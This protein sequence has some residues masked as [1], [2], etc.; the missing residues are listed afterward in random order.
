MSGDIFEVIRDRMETFSASQKIIAGMILKDYAQVVNM[1]SRDLAKALSVSPSTVVRFAA[2]LGYESYPGMLRSLRK[3]LLTALDPPMKKIHDTVS[4]LQAGPMDKLLE[5]VVAHETSLLSSIH[6]D[7]INAV[8][9]RVADFFADARDIFIT[10]ARSSFPI[11]DYAGYMMRNLYKNVSAFPSSS[12]DRYERLEDLNGSDMVIC[13]SLHRYYKSTVDV[14]RFAKSKGAFVVG[15]TDYATSPIIRHCGEVLLLPGDRSRLA[16][17]IEIVCLL[18]AMVFAF[19]Q[20]KGDSAKEFLKKRAE[21]MMQE[22]MY[23][24]M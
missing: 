2:A 14:A 20:I 11:A 10:G 6:N 18:D 21:V 12:D 1:S 9:C 19:M 23:E 22:N 5:K 24:D 8:F 13:I 3:N 15:I 4:H 16:T 17:Y 7:E